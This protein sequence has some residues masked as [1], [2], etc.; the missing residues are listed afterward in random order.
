MKN[1]E[2]YFSAQQ[3]IVFKQ[4][5]NNEDFFGSIKINII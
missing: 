1:E 3:L 4:M 5:S 2:L